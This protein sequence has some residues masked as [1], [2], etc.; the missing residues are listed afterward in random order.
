VRTVGLYSVLRSDRRKIG[1]SVALCVLVVIGLV[2]APSAGAT[3][4]SFKWTGAAAEGTRGWSD[5]ANWEADGTPSSSGSVALEF[6]M[7]TSAGCISSS[8]TD[9]CYESENNVSGLN[10][11]L[12]RVDDSHEYVI[13]GRPITLDGYGLS[14]LPATNTSKP[15]V[16]LVAL[17]ITLGAEQAWHIDGQNSDEA[18]DENQ[19][20]LVDSVSGESHRLTVDVADSG[21]LDLAND[22]EV[23]PLS[24]EGASFI[25]PDILNGVV[26]LLGAKL[27]ASN[28]EPVSLSHLFVVGTGAT[29]PLKTDAIELLVRPGGDH[30][31]PL[32]VKSA[33]LDRESWVDFDVVD[34]GATPGLDYAQLASKGPIELDDAKLGVVAEDSCTAL[35]S[36]QTYTLITTAGNIT[37]SFGNAGEDEEIPVE[38]PK[39]CAMGKQ[40]LRI[41][42]DRN[43]GTK[44]V[45]ATV[46]APRD[47]GAGL[48]LP[49]NTINPYVR[50]E[51]SSEWGAIAGT[52]SIAEYWNTQRALEEAERKARAALESKQSTIAEASLAS[53]DIAVQSNGMALVKLKCSGSASCVGKLTLTAVATSKGKHKRSHT[54]A[55]G[56]AGFSIAAGKAASVN[57]KLNATG[58]A[59]LSADH[60]HL[61][62]RLTIDQSAP[63]PAHTQTKGVDLLQR[64]VHGSKKK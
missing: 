20:L 43:G 23:G 61:S 46:T 3:V 56:T 40:H 42:Y 32:E 5:S 18:I 13:A 22:N 50:D 30:A 7:L 47:E 35:T 58:R 53:I 48:P 64:K 6:P 39:S 11:E 38:Y 8:P 63:A 2:L 27:N 57:L 16:S 29:G 21:G 33:T 44:T 10:V 41:E 1:T 4:S 45:T 12:M 26:E 37:G 55:I 9:T 19:L 15:I 28:G 24:L 62:A 14:A 34:A 59:L 54:T 36:G 31:E 49:V 60:G 17:P 51:D 52:L 25:R